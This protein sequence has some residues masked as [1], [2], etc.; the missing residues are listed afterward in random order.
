MD[1][2]A[3]IY[4]GFVIFIAYLVRGVA[5]FGSGLIS[6]PLL[7][8]QFPLTVVVPVVVLLDYLGSASQG[9]KNREHIAW[10]EQLPLIP[11]TLLGVGEGLLLLSAVTAVMLG[12]ALG[13]F[14]IAYA[15]YQ[16]LPLP[17][18]HGSRLLAI[19]YGLL[20]GFMGTL[21]GTGGPFYVIYFNLR[22]LPKHSFR[23]TFA[24]NFL[25]DGAIRITAYA[26]I[27][28]FQRDVLIFLLTA[29]PIA[30]AG[31]YLGGRIHL[32]L[33]RETFLRFISVLLLASGT[34]LLL[35]T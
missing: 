11:F 3:G 2:Q 6:V 13:G 26:T 14:I 5:G 9:I 30:A 4:A 24:T 10:R 17:T 8:L 21:F 25:I 16:L 34:V 31:L 22:D 15:I 28:F 7:A 18:L 33:S 20:G 35:K 29:L 19:P 12:K 32:D 1:L 27:G 23:A